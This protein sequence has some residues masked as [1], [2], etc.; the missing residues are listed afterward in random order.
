MTIPF[1]SYLTGKFKGIEEVSFNPIVLE[2]RQ[3][4]EFFTCLILEDSCA[5]QMEGRSILGHA[6]LGCI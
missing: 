4:L 3:I 2:K 6:S 5:R 1:T